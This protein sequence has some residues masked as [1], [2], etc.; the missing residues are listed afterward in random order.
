MISFNKSI[1]KFIDKNL[2]IIIANSSKDGNE[3]NKG[4]KSD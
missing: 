4:R 3:I 2:L 1:N